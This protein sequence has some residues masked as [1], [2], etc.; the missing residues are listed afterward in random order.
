MINVPVN[1]I[2]I[3]DGKAVIAGRH[4]KVKMIVN[5]YL[6]DGVSFQEVME[7]YHLNEAEVYSA[8]AYYYDNR[9]EFDRQYDEDEALVEKIGID[10]D[11]H[12]AELQA[13][14]KNKK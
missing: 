12:L 14:L 13:R 1:H 3:V 9:E 5:M 2:E 10:S 7:Q 11:Q 4:V 6:R 8:L